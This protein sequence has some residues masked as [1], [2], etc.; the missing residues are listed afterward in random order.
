MARSKRR[1]RRAANP[2]QN[3]QQ[4]VR[5]DH[6]IIANR[7]ARLPAIFV[8]PRSGRALRVLEDR[9]VTALSNFRPA[10]A[11][12]RALPATLSVSPS[13]AGRAPLSG[14]SFDAPKRVLI[15]VRRGIRK[16]VI[17]ALGKAG[18]RGRGAKRRRTAHS[19]VSC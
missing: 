14:L 9:R 11:G 4:S 15:C 8:P 12:V 16:Q 5:R 3:H 6:L 7:P 18:K 10:R 2:T 17:H 1:S 13:K 19:G